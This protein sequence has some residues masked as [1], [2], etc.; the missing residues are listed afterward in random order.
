MRPR[1]SSTEDTDRL[2]GSW[3]SLDLAFS[4]ALK[5][6]IAASS[7]DGVVKDD[8]ESRSEK[9]SVFF[10]ASVE[11]NLRAQAGTV[12]RGNCLR[13]SART[14]RAPSLTAAMMSKLRVFEGVA[15]N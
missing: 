11:A 1:Q 13:P 6:S 2:P 8:A 4:A 12:R 5:V 7:G 10:S 15:R 14:M 9:A 3:L